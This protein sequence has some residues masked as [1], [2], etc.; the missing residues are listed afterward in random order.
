MSAIERS[1]FP[2]AVVRNKETTTVMYRLK[3]KIDVHPI[4][5]WA[6]GKTQ[7]LPMLLPKIPAFY[8]RYVEP[9]F[10]G[11][12]LFFAVQPE[13]ALIADSNPE[14]VNLYRQIA[15]DVDGVVKCLKEF[16]NTAEE[17]LRVRALDWKTLDPPLA[18]ARMIYLNR[19]CYNG[20]YRVNRR[21]EFNVPFGD[22]KN[23]RI[24]DETNLK[25]AA[26]L[27]RRADIRCAD[28]E[29]LLDG[30][31][32]GGDFVFLDPPYVPVGEYGDFKRYTKE[33]FNDEDQVRLAKAVD[34]LHRRGAYAILT[35]SNH[36]RV[37]ELY[38]SYPIEVFQTKRNIS[39][40][41]R[42]RRGEDAVVS[43]IP[44]SAKDRER[45]KTLCLPDQVA[46]YPRTRFMGSKR[47]LLAE[48]WKVASRFE[49]DTVVDLF[50]G[51][52]I[53][54][55]MFK[56][57]GKRVISNDHM[58]MAST[59]TK[60]MVENNGIV[61]HENEIEGLMTSSG[62][63]DGFVSRTFRGLYYT[64]AENELIDVL[65]GNI[66]RMLDPYK[67]AIAMAALIRACTKKRPR[68]LFTYT[69]LRYDDGRK[70]LTKS[71]EQQFREAVQAINAAVFNNGL[72]NVSVN[73]DALELPECHPD[74]VYIDPPYYTPNSD[75]EYVRRY[76]FIEGLA[77]DWS[78]VE[79]QEHTT[80]KKFRSYFTPFSTRE[81]ATL[82]F[83]MLFSKYRDSLLIVSYSS[84]SLPGKDEMVELIR[85]YK[86]NVDV[87]PI[88]YR[89]HFGNRGDGHV[90]RNKVQEYLFVGY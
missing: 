79:I 44:A 41:S 3:G 54:G 77:R 23:P 56:A 4:L 58:Y 37:R 6:G 64:D 19:T 16:S 88:D 30:E 80:T 40:R 45:Y 63:N 71:L 25:A 8:D 31:V 78:G 76:H 1:R 47:K 65:R 62:A 89:Y 21:G 52:G 72:E 5:K 7:L 14:L 57:Q 32:C 24:C 27:L 67:R 36:S 61:L 81:G 33:Q 12:A 49:F 38:A 59:F 35:N 13:R 50:S 74:L 86:Q 28:C 60:A 87:V 11:G 22:Y 66:S 68:G 83:E 20:L 82:A 73:G 15:A 42:S 55:Y 70:D 84:N 46:C 69:G 85:R 43:I 75:N 17:F 2:F 90:K 39:C 26:Q 53:V 29:E 10:G 51:S 48:I 18:A 34:R 9:F